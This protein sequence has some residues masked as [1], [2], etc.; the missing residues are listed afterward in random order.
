MELLL[1]LSLNA[2]TLGLC[3]SVPYPGWPGGLIPCGP[4]IMGALA[5]LVMEALP[6]LMVRLAHT[7]FTKW[8]W[9]DGG[10]HSS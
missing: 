1:G 8:S 10:G 7:G 2:S 3:L 4:G 6:E 5:T 9:G